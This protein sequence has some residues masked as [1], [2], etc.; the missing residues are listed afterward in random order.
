MVVMRNVYKLHSE[1]LNVRDHLG[2]PGIDGSDIKTNVREIACGVQ[3][4]LNR[5][6]RGAFG[7]TVMN[8]RVS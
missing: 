2:D 1:N 3:T 5:L 6:R 8:F 7:N 4:R